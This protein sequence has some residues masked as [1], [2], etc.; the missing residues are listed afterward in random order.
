MPGRHA[1]E[2]ALNEPSARRK[3]G[4]ELIVQPLLNATVAWPTSEEFS[5]G[6][7]R[8]SVNRQGGMAAGA[9]LVSD[10]GKGLG[11]PPGPVA[12]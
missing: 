12:R 4:I 10:T 3:I 2:Y 6:Q 9:D 8:Q 11:S 1:S 7:G 5:N